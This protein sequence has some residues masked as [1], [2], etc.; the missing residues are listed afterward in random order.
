MR[1]GTIV[2]SATFYFIGGLF[3]VLPMLESLLFIKDPVKFFIGLNVFIMIGCCYLILY[4]II[5]EQ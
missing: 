4:G 5:N 1:I 2:L 3:G